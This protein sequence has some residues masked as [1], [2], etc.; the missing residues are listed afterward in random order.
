MIWLGI[1][2]GAEGACV[3]VDDFGRVRLSLTADGY[4]GEPGYYVDRLPDPARLHDA[5][6]LAECGDDDD[7]RRLR[8]PACHLDAIKARKHHIQ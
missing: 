6:P 1:D 2:P 8:H 7:R 4:R 3:A 5:L